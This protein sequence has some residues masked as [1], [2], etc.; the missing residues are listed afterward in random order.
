M[1]A[2]Y[3]RL[4]DNRGGCCQLGRGEEGNSSKRPERGAACLALED[5]KNKQDENPIIL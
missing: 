3:Y 5:A 1:G 2:G 4:D